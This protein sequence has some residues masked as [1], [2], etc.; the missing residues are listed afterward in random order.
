[1]K[2]LLVLIVPALSAF[3]DDAAAVRRDL[4]KE[5][6]ALGARCEEAGLVEEAARE[7]QAAR[8][9][10]PAV[11]GAAEALARIGKPWV[12]EW[13]E[14]LHANFVA[15]AKDR[16]ALLDR[17]AARWL[18]LGDARSALTLSPDFEPAHDRAGEVFAGGE[19]VRREV[20]DFLLQDL[21]PIDGKW[22]PAADVKKRRAAWAEAWEIRGTH[23]AVRSNR[24]EPAAREV[25]ALAEAVFAAVHR[26]L[27]GE[28][29]APA[30]KKRFAVYDFATRAD[31]LAHLD[32]VH[33]GGAER[34]SSAGFFSSLDAA[35][36][37]A[38]TGNGFG[39]GDPDV[40]RHEV[41]HQVCDA[42]WP[43]QGMLAERPHFWAWEGVAAFF[44]STKIRDGKI[45]VGSR[46]HPRMG[47]ARG[48]LKDGATLPLDEFVLL[49]GEGVKGRYNQAASL[50]HFFLLSDGGKGRER[51]LK[52]L[53]VVASG[54]A[55]AD[56]FE[57][58]FGC[59]AGK[60]QEDWEAWV[61]GSG[62]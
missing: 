5:R 50:V 18:A 48:A 42:L 40:V 56:T 37:F 13:D 51:F 28:L 1:M 17:F 53:R 21:L 9:E 30:P 52:Y 45:L 20:A 54:K 58:S 7:W 39:L 33:E 6:A 24:S 16:S 31:F 61:K 41:A 62:R 32:A 29:D 12:L 15:Y 43:P 35:S 4:A 10:D 22:L 59:K 60:F 2:S 11:A 34:R 3:A 19:W 25:L 26:E 38:P 14:A 36:H 46:L 47:M 8:R 23:F 44:E 49:D 57:K 27:E 55:E